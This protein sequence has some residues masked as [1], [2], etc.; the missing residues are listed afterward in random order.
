MSMGFAHS[1]SVETYW[2]D[3]CGGD[4]AKLLGGAALRQQALILQTF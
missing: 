3:C 1:R 2:P 4:G